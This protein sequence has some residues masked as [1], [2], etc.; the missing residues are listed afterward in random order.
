MQKLHV[1]LNAD[2]K[3]TPVE[4][5]LGGNWEITFEDGYPCVRILSGNMYA[6]P[7]SV[8]EMKVASDK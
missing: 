5:I 3:F 7:I 1:V 4:R 8:N 2:N 6:Q